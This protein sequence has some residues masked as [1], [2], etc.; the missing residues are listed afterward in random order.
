MPLM[1]HDWVTWTQ[2]PDREFTHVKRIADAARKVGYRLVTHV[3]C[4]RNR[5]LWA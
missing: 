4:L 3:E 2:A 1:L 5:D